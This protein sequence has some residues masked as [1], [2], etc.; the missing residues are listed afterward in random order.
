MIRNI[1]YYRCKKCHH[2]LT[3]ASERATE[4]TKH[5][6]IQ[7]GDVADSWKDG[8]LFWELLNKGKVKEA[9]ELLRK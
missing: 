9:E 6:C 8:R 1:L 4:S 5:I 3:I 2:L 7:C